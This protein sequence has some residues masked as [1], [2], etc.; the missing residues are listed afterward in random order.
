MSPILGVNTL[1][2][3]WPLNLF[4]YF[5]VCMCSCVEILGILPYHSRLY[6]LDIGNVTEPENRLAVSKP[7]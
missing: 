4:G 3:A 6:S 5:C 1:S 2:H 7:Q